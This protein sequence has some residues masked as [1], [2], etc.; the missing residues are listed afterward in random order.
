MPEVVILDDATG[1]NDL[2]MNAALAATPSGYSNVGGPGQAHYGGAMHYFG[3]V[4]E[5][6][7]AGAM[8]GLFH[9]HAIAHER[10]VEDEMGGFNHYAIDVVGKTRDRFPRKFTEVYHSEVQ[11]KG[12]SKQYVVRTQKSTKYP[13]VKSRLSWDREAKV[14]RLD[15]IE[16]TTKGGIKDIFDKLGGLAVALKILKENE[17]LEK[18]GGKE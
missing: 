3:E 2:S 7:L 13:T 10:I 8:M 1:L 11:T 9:F 15:E 16:D 17:T 4:T 5:S 6:L 18:V 14:N 12:G